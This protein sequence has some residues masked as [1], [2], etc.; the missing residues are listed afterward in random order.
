MNRRFFP[1]AFM[2]CSHENSKA[3][4]RFFEQLKALCSKLD[5]PFDPKWFVTDACKATKKAISTVFKDCKTIM[6]WF[7][8]KY[9]LRKIKSTIQDYK[10]TMKEIDKLHRCT[11]E[12]SYKVLTR[13][14][15][16]KIIKQVLEDILC[17]NIL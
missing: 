9:N 1:L 13:S 16:V 17:L 15:K 2:I 4:I 14:Y 5:L 8:L 7:H 12:G 10:Q 6:C 3:F 11:D